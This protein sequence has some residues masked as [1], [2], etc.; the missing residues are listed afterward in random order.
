M[1]CGRRVRAATV[2]AAAFFASCLSV[3]AGPARAGDD[4]GTQWLLF[5]GGDIW[6]NGAF[7]N[8]GLLWSPG[9]LDREGFT[10]KTVLS[11]GL[12]RYSSGALAGEQVVGTE[13]AAQIL[14]G[15][16]FKR[17]GFEAKAFLGLDLQD[18]RLAPDDPSSRLRG[19][20]VG[21]RIAMDLWSEPTPAS[22]IAADGSLSTIIDSYSARIAYGWRLMDAFY[23]GPEAQ[24]YACEG[25]RQLRFGVH[26]TALK[27]NDIEW[28]VAGGWSDDS[29][30]R[31]SPYLRIGILTRR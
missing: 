21:A 2:L 6:R 23:L 8:G 27:F 29:D 3:A 1:R 18:H 31:Q 30:R 16:H 13:Y 25:Y 24:T 4:G 20:S 5:S 7:S 26:I 11:G 10:L 28:S 17:D 14:P 19:A 15:W 22:M 12:Y 9:G